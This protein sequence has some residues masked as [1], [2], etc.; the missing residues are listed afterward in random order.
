MSQRTTAPEPDADAADGTGG[1]AEPSAS[2]A[3]GG[4]GAPGEPG[5]PGRDDA[6]ASPSSAAS[7]PAEH[8]FFRWM[9][10]L[11][12]PRRPGWIGGVAAGIAE[13]LGLDPIL[14]RG[15]LVV[16]AVL[17][18][19]AILLYAVAWFLLP[20]P[21]DTIPAQELGR[22]R[23]GRV[24]L[25]IG[26]LVLL[27]FLPL[28]QGFWYAGALY[29]GEPDAA[30][31]VGRILWTGVLLALA[32]VAVVWI[33]RRAAAQSPSADGAAAT[34]TT[35][36]ASN[37]DDD[38]TETSVGPVGSTTASSATASA[39]TAS[40]TATT[41][42]V[43]SRAAAEPTPPPAPPADASTEELAEWR[44][45]QDEWHR[46]RALWAA[47][48]K[49][50][51]REQR[52][53]LAHDEAVRRAAQAVEFRRIERLTRPR[54]SAAVVGLIFGAAL[55]AGGALALVASTTPALAGDVVPIA[56]AAAAV[57][58]GLG[59]VAVGIARRRSGMLAF[60]GIVGVTATVISGAAGLL[61]PED[62]EPLAPG[63][64]LSNSLS[65][66]FSQ[67]IGDMQ[68]GIYPDFPSGSTIDVW[69]VEGNVTV[70]VAE[71]TSVRIESTGADFVGVDLWTS[72][73]FTDS[74]AEQ[75]D[76]SGRYTATFGDG[77]VE[78]TVR[79]HQEFGYVT[80]VMDL[81][82]PADA[83]IDPRPSWLDAI[84][85]EQPTP[86]PAPTEGDG[87]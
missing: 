58:L 2:G 39:T 69:K 50:T 19:P 15:I 40:D 34:A 51:E 18:G 6:S 31:S 38:P 54:A 77:P 52:Q 8:A 23:P 11:D 76:S 24:L 73:E 60:L 46:Q 1:P 65:G 72:G 30:G 55:A 14:V 33:A 59:A 86:P 64:S 12:V 74:Y 17:G 28:T 25:G 27:S 36:T 21:D 32:V 56:I 3:S 87:Q 71:G 78:A 67:P 70:W 84:A 83:V 68:I 85:P 66:S 26:G 42:A 47:E 81:D 62:R 22:G 48:Q 53:R 61:L 49:R 35:G 4:S 80:A 82:D 20:G 79:I 5:D 75:I 13:K 41:T 45:G 9:R 16:V 57:V 44:R 29:W 37:S 43:G 63:Y 10:G 7:A